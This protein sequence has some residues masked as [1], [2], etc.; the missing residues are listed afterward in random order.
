VGAHLEGV[1]FRDW[2]TFRRP[3]LKGKW[4][5][6]CS[7][8]VAS[9]AIG[10]PSRHVYWSEFVSDLLSFRSQKLTLVGCWVRP[11]VISDWIIFKLF[12]NYC[13][14]EQSVFPK[15][16]RILNRYF[17]FSSFIV[18]LSWGRLWHLQ[19]FLQCIKYTIHT[20]STILLYP[21]LSQFLK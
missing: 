13:H 21:F 16:K 4:N 12:V 11:V 9:N 19:R 6:I 14:G 15:F 18:G 10:W 20:S 8:M 3:T 7:S 17:C 5:V 1:E 2:P